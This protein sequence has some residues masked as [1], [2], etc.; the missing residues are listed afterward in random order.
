MTVSDD[1]EEFRSM[2][3][4]CAVNNNKSISDEELS[5]AARFTD[6]LPLAS[7]AGLFTAVPRIVNVVTL[8]EGHPVKGCVP[9]TT[10]PFDLHSIAARLNCAFY[11]PQSFAAVQV[12]FSAPRARVL[13][14]HT[15]R[16]VGTGSSSLESARLALARVQ[17]ALAEEAQIFIEI[18]K[19][20]I[21]NV[22]SAASIGA[23]FKTENFARG[24]KANAHYDDKSFVGL[25]WRPRNEAVSAE[26]YGTGRVNL[27]GGKRFVDVCR[28]WSRMVPELLR[29]SSAPSLAKGFSTG[30]QEACRGSGSDPVTEGTKGM[31][32]E[33][34][35]GIGTGGASSKASRRRGGRRT[36]H[37]DDD[38]SRVEEE[39]ESEGEDEE[40]AYSTAFGADEDTMIKELMARSDLPF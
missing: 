28:S 36:G 19:F 18:R 1:E 25:A 6:R 7:Y 40:R 3:S 21:V 23:T 11:A 10:L 37:D 24:H 29:Y 17:R 27:P 38:G 22:V 15:G 33:D 9:Q 4:V 26:I 12:S 34:R 16:L 8:S 30:D 31:W 2:C 32:L 5:E 14:F 20:E 13:I 39:D 35:A